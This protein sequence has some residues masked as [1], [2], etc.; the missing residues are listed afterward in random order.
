M[1]DKSEL[2]RKALRLENLLIGYNVVEAVVAIGAGISAGSIALVGFGLDSII[3]VTAAATLVWRLKKHGADDPDAETRAEKRA[4]FIIGVTF[5]LLAAYVLYESAGTLWSRQA[6]R[7]S[8]LGI[9][10]AILSLIVMP[11]LGLPRGG[12]PANLEARLWRRTPWKR[13]FAPGFPRSFWRASGSTPFWAGGGPI[14]WL[15]WPWSL[16]F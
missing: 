6:P 7:E 11:Y 15:D 3:E 8:L 12:S 2:V 13:S 9:A 14:L 5:L 1:N 4:L 16:L 10:L